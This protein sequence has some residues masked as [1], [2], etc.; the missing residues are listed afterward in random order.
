MLILHD[1]HAVFFH[2]IVFDPVGI[3]HVGAVRIF[4]QNAVGKAPDQAKGHS[5]NRHHTDTDQ[6]RQPLALERRAAGLG[7]WEF[8]FLCHAYFLLTMI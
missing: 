7:R 4:H 8:C 2:G 3:H 1:P 6:D 5:Q